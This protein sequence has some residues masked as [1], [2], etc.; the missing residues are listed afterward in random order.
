MVRT[1]AS[2]FQVQGYDGTGFSE[3]L[4]RSGA[5][6]GAIY[7]H[8]P[9]GKEELATEVVERGQEEIAQ[10]I[11]RTLAVAKSPAAAIRV[12]FE[13]S[14]A[15]LEKSKFTRGCPL[16]TL[17]LE[18][19]HRSERIRMSAARALD[20]WVSVMQQALIS[21]HVPRREA[22]RLVM[23]VLS[24]Y[25]GALLLSRAQRDVTPLRET[26]IQLGDIVEATISA[27]REAR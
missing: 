7:F 24:A 12:F 26:A 11:R 15:N 3:I 13:E 27:R 4:R 23:L 6:R 1:A 2:L 25:E 9:G 5:A 10:R 22:R 16:A 21:A 20:V 17:I 18:T 8:F 19:A 14:A